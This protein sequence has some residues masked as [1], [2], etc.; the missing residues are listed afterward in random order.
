MT[1][2]PLFRKI[3]ARLSEKGLDDD[4]FERCAQDLLR[5][6]YPG[7]VPVTG[8]DD[9]GFDGAIGSP[10]GPYP[11]VCT[12]GGDAVGNLRKNLTTYLAKRRGP[13][14]AVFA[15]PRALTP[16][17]K[18]NLADAATALGVTLVNVHDQADFANRLYRSPR[19]R[20]DLLGVTGDPPA[21][22]ALPARGRY[23][24]PGV[25][26]GREA[27]V[28]WLRSTPGDLLLVG[29][30]GC[31]KTY[32]HQHL[33]A[34]GLCLF[35]VDADPGR[36]ADAVREQV[37]AVVV[38][39]D[40]HV[41]PG[42]LRGLV[43]LRAECGAAFAIHAN[44]W[45]GS[46]RELRAVL[47]VGPG[48]VRPL[49]PLP[50][51]LVLRLIEQNGIYG[52]DELLH[53]LLDQ[54]G[55]MPGLAAALCEACKR[56]GVQRVWSGEAL[57]DLLLYDPRL[58]PGERERAVLAA[59]ALGGRAGMRSADVA[60]CL[61]LPQ[62]DL[63]AATAGLGAGGVVAE[64][65]P[66]R[67]RVR[68]EALAA[69]LVRDVFFGGPASL[70]PGPLLA[71]APSPAAAA[72]VLMSARQRGA[73]VPAD[74][75]EPLVLAAED[76]QG[77][78]EHFAW[79][80]EACARAVI[81][82]FPERACLAATGLLHFS[83][84]RALRL[85][86]AA[87]AAGAVRSESA[88]E[89]PR[90]RVTD[91]LVGNLEPGTTVE[92]RLL[93]LAAVDGWRGE[94]AGG[95]ASGTVGWA[96]G[97]ALRPNVHTMRT[98]PG[99]GSDFVVTQGLLTQADLAGVADL[100][101]RIREA[102]PSLPV[103]GWRAVLDAVEAWCF[104]GRFGFGQAVP[105][106]RDR[107][108]RDAGR[109]M[110][111]DV[112]ALPGCPRACRT[113]AARHNEWANL[114]LAVTEDPV[115]AVLFADRDHDPDGR[116][117]WDR[118]ERELRGLAARFAG[119]PAGEAVDELW[120]VDREVAEFGSMGGGDGRGYL[121]HF[122]GQGAADPDGWLAALVRREMSAEYVQP[123][124][125]AVG[126]CDRARSE[127]WFRD[128]LG[129]PTYI[130]MAARVALTS[131]AV[132]DALVEE[133]VRK[134]VPPAGERG[135]H[136]MMG[137]Q[138]SEPTAAR[139]LRHPAPAVR[140]AA[141]VAEWTREHPGGTVR[142]LV[143]EA[144][145]SAVPDIAAGDH[146][147][148]DIFASHPELALAWVEHL[149]ARVGPAEYVDS[150]GVCRAAAVLGR[151]ERRR[152]L[153]RVGG[154][155]YREE[156][157]DALVGDDADLFAEWFTAQ[158]GGYFRLKPLDR[159]VS[160]RWEQMALAALR[161]GATPDEVADHCTPTH[162]EISGSRSAYWRGLLPAY[163]R[164]AEH[165][166]ARLRLAGRRGLEWAHWNLEKGLESERREAV[167]GR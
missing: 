106:E 80:D 57:A 5:D 141:A 42:R 10:G 157:F 29:Q 160:P 165:P 155:N 2:D 99:T 132:S 68:P 18:R 21:L 81:E 3:V 144:W 154:D 24:P 84:D 131:A 162:W 76:D 114:G 134:V 120:S 150:F 15:T 70:D 62:V 102:L 88:I 25:P 50:R 126:R 48:S 28:E 97:E 61:G 14:L 133:A 86:L 39:D 67:L 77:V 20:R 93:L 91:W 78:W 92:R 112:L 115:F 47:S 6:T 71:A 167:Y 123:F 8:G 94:A 101:P 43:R 121:Y 60:V 149:L 64:D 153:A 147:L 109:R 46:E 163:E 117:A 129:R 127:H 31:G 59:F 118:R 130:A 17:R 119:R 11:L 164:L 49:D 51:P 113:W 152:L 45:P 79:V 137:W 66:D 166:D 156:G 27:E 139:L 19:W 72:H 158:P 55:G 36:L 23:A 9:A 63:R 145:R 85:L 16:R 89:H 26:V 34:A 53:V 74:L 125:E 54:A 95:A 87:D 110:I 100:W 104:P 56:S 58:V 161:S 138:V 135:Q 73:R 148:G 90:R 107:Y 12:V 75:L 122:A 98:K 44:C 37:P 35:A 82:R 13:P 41:D 40:A 32:L 22:S 136:W 128:L 38:L 103:G 30:P 33:A 96:L 1:S 83:P 111:A 52:P 65:G 159:L 116:A 140:G 105:A 151:D 7:L 4:A 146:Y 124:L 108:M 69:V 142:P 143:V